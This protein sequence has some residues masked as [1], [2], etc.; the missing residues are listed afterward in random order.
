MNRLVVPLRLYS[1]SKR[2]SWPRLSRNRLAYR[3]DQLGRALVETDHRAFRIGRFGIEVEHVLHAGDELA[4]DLRNAPHVLA[5][6]LE[7]V[8][9]HAPAHGLPG[10]VVMLGEA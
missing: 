6:G 2:S 7:L 8:F 5:P 1:Q 9:S 3:A 10:D 4:V